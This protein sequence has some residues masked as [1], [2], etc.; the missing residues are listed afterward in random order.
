[1][2]VVPEPS[3]RWMTT[4]AWLGSLTPGLSLTIR[5]SFHFAIW[6]RKMPAS[7]GP[8]R[9][10]LA[11]RDAGNVHHRHDAADDGGKLSQAHRRQGLGFE[12]HVGS[13]ESHRLGLDLRDAAARADGL[14]VEADPADLLIRPRPFGVDRIG[15]R[16]AGARDAG[17]HAPAAIAAATTI[18]AAAATRTFNAF[19]SRHLQPDSGAGTLSHAK[20][21]GAALRPPLPCIVCPPTRRTVKCRQLTCRNLGSASSLPRS[22]W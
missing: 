4:M 14:V 11:R 18:A 22:P 3:E 7:V 5:G 21:T 13:P 8:S 20:E 6:P 15:K 12:R 9:T 19:I 17:G 1:M 16:R 10:M 2:N